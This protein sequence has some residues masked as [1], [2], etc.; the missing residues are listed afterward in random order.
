M[1]VNGEK[2]EVE[3]RQFFHYLCSKCRFRAKCMIV[4][5]KKQWIII[6]LC[7]MTT[8]MLKPLE[9][10][11]FVKPSIFG[12]WLNGS[13]R[14]TRSK[15]QGYPRSGI[16][17]H[18]WNES[19]RGTFCTLKC[20]ILPMFPS[21]WCKKLFWPFG[22]RMLIGFWILDIPVSSTGILKFPVTELVF[23]LNYWA[24]DYLSINSLHGDWK[25]WFYWCLCFLASLGKFLNFF[26]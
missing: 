17:Q 21:H 18:R 19:T 6:W 1:A 16:N 13:N 8:E 3:W 24:L 10:Q 12:A 23:L 5:C 20:Y 14:T 11:F 25:H 22:H 7:A 15:L 4:Q 9:E 2:W 26:S